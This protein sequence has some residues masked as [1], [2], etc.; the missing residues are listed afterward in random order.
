[1]LRFPNRDRSCLLSRNFSSTGSRRVAN[2]IAQS[3][4]DCGISANNLEWLS[5]AAMHFPT[6]FAAPPSTWLNLPTKSYRV[7]VS[8]NL[9]PLGAWRRY[10]L[11]YFD[12]TVP[13]ILPQRDYGSK[14]PLCNFFPDPL[15]VHF[16]VKRFYNCGD[17]NTTIVF[18][19]NPMYWLCRNVFRFIE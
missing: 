10:I 2:Y 11:F 8:L 15:L 5:Q 16:A 6:T 18:F 3:L 19:F 12:S 1:M 4:S 9:F 17:C 14:Y 7:T 13:S